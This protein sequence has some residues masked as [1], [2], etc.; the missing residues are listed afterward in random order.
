MDWRGEEGRG[1]EGG[2]EIRG[3][4]DNTHIHHSAENSNYPFTVW[5]QR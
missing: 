4:E 3:S 5:L 1:G 2:R